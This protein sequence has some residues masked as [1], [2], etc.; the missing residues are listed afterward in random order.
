VT[1]AVQ[2]NGRLRGTVQVPAG[3]DEM[4][5]QQAALAE[6]NV[7]KHVAGQSIQQVVVVPGRVVNI[8]V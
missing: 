6:P 3:A 7:Q 2:V 4:A 8:V 5:V 1:L